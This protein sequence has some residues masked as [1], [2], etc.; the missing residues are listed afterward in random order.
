VLENVHAAADLR[1]LAARKAKPDEYKSVRHPLVEEEVTKGWTVA[2][3]NRTITRLK[4][5]KTTDRLLEDRVWTLLYRM[6][7]SHL[8]GSGGAH[9]LLK[10]DDPKTP[11]NQIDV[12]SIDDEVA[13]AIECKSSAKPK[14]FVDFTRDLAKH[15]SLRD[16]FTASIKNQFPVA[17]KRPSI[18]AIWTLGLIF[19]DNDRT[20]AEDAGVPLLEESDLLYYE[21]LVN[22]IGPAARFQFL[23]DILQGRPVPGLQ[24]TVP[25]IRTKMGGSTAYTFS[26]SP[27]YLLKVAFVSHRARGKASDIDAYQRMLKRARLRSIR[28]YIAEGGIFPTNIVVNIADPKWLSFDRGKQEGGKDTPSTFGWLHIRPAYRVAWIIDGQHRLFSYAGHPLARKSVISVMAFVGQ[29]ASEQARLFVDINAQQRKVKQSLLQELYAELHWDADDP[30]TRVQAILSKVI[31]GLDVELGSPFHKR[32][33][34]ADDARTELRCISLTSVF[35]AMEKSGFFIARTKKGQVVEFGP[36]WDVDNQST[37]RRTVR[38]LTE[39]FNAIRAEATHLWDLGSADGGGLAMNDGVTVCINV[40]RSVLHHLE[41]VKRLP[42]GTMTDDELTEVVSPF[43]AHVGR[44]FASLTPEQVVHFRS[45]R[46]VQGQTTATRRVEEA[47]R[48]LEPT[49]DPPGL[50][51]FLVRE[52]TQTTTKAFQII[53]R[54]E[55]ILQRTVLD[56]LKSEFGSTEQEWWFNGVPKGVRKK[57]DDRIN[58]EG[59]KKGGRE[60]SFD[61]IDYRE[62]I[63]NNW[64]SF[65]AVLARGKGSKDARTKWIVEVNDL[66]KPVMHAS[67]GVSLPITEEQLAFL[68]EIEQWLEAQVSEPLSEEELGTPEGVQ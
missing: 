25:A 33:L 54:I 65:E 60:E 8:S 4:R 22:Q 10:P 58:E 64:T 56:E 6:G 40:L 1:G 18:F 30:E 31:Q 15:T 49:F 35:R 28:Q 20:R 63:T 61:L 67:K 55:T 37:L 11:D 19:T 32:I 17:H 68:E 26:V 51:D 59:G 34:K 43:A 66:R 41:N 3:R 45:L 12:V 9:L 50:S 38:I 14:K 13:F 53:H 29:P 44:Y 47:I 16:N 2:R 48:R 23:A 39:Y 36:L 5:P 62:I 57:V 52:K 21:R 46:G 7:F 42:L 27:E 24:L